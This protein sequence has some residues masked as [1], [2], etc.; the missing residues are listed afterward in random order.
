VSDTR[1]LLK[2][3]EFYITN[4]CNLACENCNRFNNYNFRGWQ[5]WNDHAVDY[6]KWSELVDIESIILL[7]GE[8]LLNPTLLQ[9]IQG[10]KRLWPK[11]SLQVLTNGTR[12]NKVAGLYQALLTREFHIG[13]SLHNRLEVD[14]IFDEVERFLQAPVTKIV[15]RENNKYGA[16]YVFVDAN[17]IRIPM[18]M[19]NKFY[20]AAVKSV[21]NQF[22]LHNSDPATAHS[23]CII[24][25]FKSYHFI[26]GKLFK[27]GPV[28]LFPEFDQQFTLNLSDHDRELINSYR[29]LTVEN[30]DAYHEEFIAQLDNPLDQCK[31]CATNTE[32]K[33]IYP[34]L[35]KQTK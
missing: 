20:Q 10:I 3:I 19:D 16:D 34:L 18:W 1:I 27:C 23:N 5:N 25:Q 31:F 11:A 13:V 29:P 7:G 30:F 35:K 24:A 4:V 9:W 21:D 6:Q 33:E 12:L 8:P 22:T 32:L 14:V 2:K 15:G 17:Q 26:R 28:A